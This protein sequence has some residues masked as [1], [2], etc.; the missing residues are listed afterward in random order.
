MCTQKLFIEVQY[1]A[2]H[3]FLHVMVKFCESYL[4]VHVA[5]PCMVLA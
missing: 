2:L 4:S 5:E 3:F 1:K